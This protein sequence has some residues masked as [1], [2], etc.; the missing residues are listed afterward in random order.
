MARRRKDLPEEWYDT[1]QN[2]LRE[3][4]DTREFIGRCLRCEMPM[5]KEAQDQ[6]EQ[7]RFVEG[8]KR[9]FFADRV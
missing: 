4:S 1:L 9:E 2:L 7:I 8:I 6:E 3:M 5:E